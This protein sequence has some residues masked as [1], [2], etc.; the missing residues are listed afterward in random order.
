MTAT[1][2]EKSRR[3]I[4]IWLLVVCALI[5]IMVVLAASRA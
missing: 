4:A 2:S 5:F 3:A 1:A